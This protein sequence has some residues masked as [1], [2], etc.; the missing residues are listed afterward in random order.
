MGFRENLGEFLEK[1][2]KE[3][4]HTVL[5]IIQEVRKTVPRFSNERLNQLL[6]GQIPRKEEVEPLSR[7]LNVHPRQLS[8]VTSQDR[9]EA[10]TVVQ[11]LKYPDKVDRYYRHKESTPFRK[12]HPKQDVMRLIADFEEF[13]ELD[14]ENEVFRLP[15]DECQLKQ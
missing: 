4:P 11:Q 5:R 6:S 14:V 3:G 8:S 9:E 12:G 7:A 2:K 13:D 15:S 1:Y 10:D